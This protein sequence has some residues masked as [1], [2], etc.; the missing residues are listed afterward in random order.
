MASIVMVCVCGILGHLPM[1]GGV[2]VAVLLISSAWQGGSFSTV[3]LSL[4]NLRSAQFTLVV[5]LWLPA[6]GLG[7]CDYW[8][9]GH[10]D[11]AGTFHG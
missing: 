6:L 4:A 8:P 1:I 10:T 2:P 7:R 9:L 3:G 5:F 11:G